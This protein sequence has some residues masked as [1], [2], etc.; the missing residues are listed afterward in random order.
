MCAACKKSGGVYLRAARLA[1][2][3]GAEVDGIEGHDRVCVPSAEV[4]ICR[5]NHTAAEQLLGEYLGML[6]SAGHEWELIAG[7]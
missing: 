4:C 7:S 1:I 5:H 2:G 6:D 3:S